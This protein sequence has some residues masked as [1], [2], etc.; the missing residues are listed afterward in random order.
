MH[1]T[2]GLADL[3]PELCHAE[4]NNFVDQ[5]LSRTVSGWKERSL[6]SAL[7]QLLWTSYM[8]ILWSKRSQKIFQDWQRLG[9]QAEY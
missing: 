5:G 9:W 4:L 1:M 7:H 8:H 2:R 6:D 3:Q